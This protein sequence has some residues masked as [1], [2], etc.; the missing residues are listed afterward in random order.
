MRNYDAVIFDLD[1]TL[2]CSEHVNRDAVVETLH[3]EVGISLTDEE[4]RMIPGR[5]SSETIAMFL[6]KKGFPKE[7][8]EKLLQKNRVRYD[9]IWDAKVK[10]MPGADAVV[11][12]LHRNGVLLAIGTTNRQSVVEKFV[13]RFDFHDIFTMIV[14]G[15]DVKRTKPDPEV[16]LIAA[17]GIGIPQ[18]RILVVED[19]EIG[20]CAAK[21]AGLACAAIPSEYSRG[22]NFTKAN[23]VLSQL[24]DILSV[25]NV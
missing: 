22:Q 24:P 17:A 14:S 3:R 21:A 6:E 2:T 9:R 20:V 4:I 12:Q 15:K 18:Q 25:I 16:Y 13:M 11:R 5:P 19:T 8:A 1:E 7:L 23:F 10:L